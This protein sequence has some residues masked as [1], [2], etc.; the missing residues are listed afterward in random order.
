[1]SY[2]I[3]TATD[4]YDLLAKIRVFVE[5]T[6]PVEDRYTVVRSVATGDDREVIWQAPGSG[7]EEIFFGLKTYQ[8]VSSDYYN[9]KIGCFTGYV[10]GNTFETQP[11][12]CTIK[13]IPLWNHDIPYWLIAN[14]RY[15][16]F[17]AKIENVYTSGIAGK[18]LP[19]NT[20]FQY[21]Y[22][23]ICGGCLATDSATRYSDT[24][25]EA[26][27]V[28]KTAF[29]LRPIEGAW[30]NV[31]FWPYKSTRVLR[32][33]INDS[34]TAAGYYGIHS[35]IMSRNTTDIYDENDNPDIFGEIEN[36]FFVSGFNNAVENTFT[37]DAV[38]Y[39][40]MRNVWRTGFADY[41]ALRL[42]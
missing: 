19:Y 39:I 42:M 30:Q 27:F 25:Y 5:S 26:W 16:A 34:D 11:G 28:G 36:I 40:M 22:P 3:D 7:G 23:V 18:F 31:D 35:I 24:S 1:M 4:H 41:V 38:P 12:H 17:F 14:G 32:N 20:P 29:E 33:T 8:S 15:F 13:G 9:F 21:P 2:E 37:I 6:L 10:S